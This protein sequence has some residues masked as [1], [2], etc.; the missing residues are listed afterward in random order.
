MKEGKEHSSDRESGKWQNN[1]RK[2]GTVY[3]NEA[4]LFL[5][6]KGMVI[7]ERNYHS[8]TGEIDIIA[9]DG[10]YLVFVEVKYRSLTAYPG[11]ALEA[12]T[13]GKQRRVIHTAKRYLFEKGYGEDTLCR[14]D[15]L[16]Y[17]GNEVCHIENA[18]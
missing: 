6:E 10:E 18:F 1:H 5:Q 3:E 13:P 8:R 11:A 9:K 12:V 14:F 4:V 7:L 2:T 17:Q 16:A 15:V